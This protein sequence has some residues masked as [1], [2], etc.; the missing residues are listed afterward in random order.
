MAGHTG[1]TWRRGKTQSRFDRFLIRLALYSIKKT[2]SNWTLTKSDH[3]AVILTLQHRDKTIT[4]KQ[5]IKL[6]N[7]IVTNYEL[8]NELKQYVEEQ[9][10]QAAQL[11][12]HIKLQFA[13]MRT[14]S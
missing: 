1:Y 3:A 9:M 13:K 5:H 10:I 8:L 2:K 6:D 14:M 11:N 7:T 12:P 4:K